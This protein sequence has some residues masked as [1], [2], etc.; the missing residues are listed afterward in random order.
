MESPQADA[1]LLK[2]RIALMS[3]TA[4]GSEFTD[5][6]ACV[7]YVRGERSS[8][9]DAIRKFKSERDR[10]AAVNVE[11]SAILKDVMPMLESY[12]KSDPR[13]V[14]KLD[15]IRAALRRAKEKT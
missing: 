2:W 8:Q 11:L 10:L 4:G 13:A 5:P 3:L 9:M 14:M 7:D 15:T 12:C 6:L 1:K